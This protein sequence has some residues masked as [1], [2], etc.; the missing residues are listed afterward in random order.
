M[1][2]KKI[3]EYI[4]EHGEDATFMTAAELGATLEVS[5]STVVRF[6]AELGYDGYPK[7][8]EAMR[9]RMLNRVPSTPMAVT[10]YSNPVA[11]KLRTEAA[12]LHQTAEA[13]STE[14]V[15][16]VI[17]AM[18]SAGHIYLLADRFSAILAEYAGHYLRLMYP[19]IHIITA[20]D[21]RET[22]EQLFY[23]DTGDVLLI[24]GF[25]EDLSAAIVGAKYCKSKGAVVIAITDSQLSPLAQESDYILVAKTGHYPIGKSLVSPMGMIQALLLE[26]CAE[27][28]EALVEQQNRLNQIL[29]EY[30]GREK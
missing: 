5:E 14:T 25:S 16:A 10:E 13:L 18:R 29:R 6:A 17:S 3:A 28:E 27:K 19:N 11:E 26:L 30:T 20:S 7:M 22:L 23:V 24:F 9:K 12:R 4:L 8:Q 21:D 15:S 1:Y 2:R